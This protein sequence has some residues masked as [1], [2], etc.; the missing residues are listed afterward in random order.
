[1]S[2]D[3]PVQQVMITLQFADLIVPLH[4]LQISRFYEMVREILPNFDQ[5]APAGPMPTSIPAMIGV[6]PEPFIASNF[7]RI[8]L[9]GS[10]ESEIFLFQHDR[11]SFAWHKSDKS[12]LYPGFEAALDR[13]F[14]FLEK[15]RSFVKDEFNG[16]ISFKA[17]EVSYIDVFKTSDSDD[18]KVRLSSIYHLF[19]PGDV[20][21][22]MAGYAFNWNEVISN[23]DGVLVTTISCPPMGPTPEALST[24]QMTATFSCSG[25]DEG[26][27]GPTIL[28][29][30]DRI[31]TSYRGL[32]HEHLQGY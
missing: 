8:R 5:V 18:K 21:F 9:S 3:A 15:Y 6:E 23:P 20:K 28:S 11:I 25:K 2:A 27:L 31:R 14:F 19:N 26:E 22:G 4:A 7:P 13:L 29:V 1:M 30:R 10:D 12:V 32:V 24:L 16:D 17:G